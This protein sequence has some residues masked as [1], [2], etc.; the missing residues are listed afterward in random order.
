MIISHKHK[1]IFIEIPHTASTAISQE[2]CT[3][4]GGEAILHKHAHLWEFLDHA[5]Q[6]EKNYF[7]IVGVRNPLDVTVTRY[8]KRRTNHN[9]FFTDPKYW[10]ENG[11]HV[12]Y[13][14]RREYEF[15]TVNDADFSQY[16]RKFYHLPYDNWGSPSPKDFN[17]ILHFE[18]LQEDFSGFLNLL[19]IDQ[20]RQ[21]PI[22]N[23]TGEKGLNYLDYYSPDIYKKASWVFGPFCTSWGYDFPENWHSR[24]DLVSSQ[25]LYLM[26]RFI[27]RRPRN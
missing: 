18:N 19:G 7:R 23:K 15:I 27:R 10:R 6:N 9:E 22:V 17:A 14:S 20:M 1:Y 16:F 24:D 26:L 5:D 25:I 13:K 3:Y 11:G 4:Y 2:L 12:S 8:F 21:I